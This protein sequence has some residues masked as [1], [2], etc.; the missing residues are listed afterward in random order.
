M[1]C[2]ALFISVSFIISFILA[3]GTAFAQTSAP[4]ASAPIIIKPKKS[5][6]KKRSEIT[7]VNN[8]QISQPEMNIQEVLLRIEDG[9]NAVK[10]VRERDDR[11]AACELANEY[12]T[13]KDRASEIERKF[14]AKEANQEGSLTPPSK[15]ENTSGIRS[16]MCGSRNGGYEVCISNGEVV[17]T[18]FK[19]SSGN[20]EKIYRQW[21]FYFEN[22][23]RQDLGFTITDSKNGTV[24]STKESHFMIFPRKYLPSIRIDGNN[25]IVTLPN[26][27]QITYDVTTKKI[28]GGVLNEDKVYNGEGVLIRAD[29][30]GDDARFAKKAN[31]TATITKKGQSCKVPKKHLWPDQSQSSALHFKF[32]TDEEFDSYLKKQ[33]G[34]GL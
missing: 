34:F 23:A 31:T 11:C 1:Q 2:K 12:S 33:C 15:D 16:S 32:V 13:G 3:Y 17:P 30:T 6:K 26:G 28:T 29:Q 24:S 22:K 14:N 5:K 8:H 21:D 4:T 7:P 10:Q 18:R 19:F 25:Q 9:N 27:E 20:I